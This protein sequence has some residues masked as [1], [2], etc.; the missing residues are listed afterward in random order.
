VRKAGRWELRDQGPPGDKIRAKI[1]MGS[2]LE[3]GLSNPPI[4][5]SRIHQTRSGQLP[6]FND[7]IDHPKT[8]HEQQQSACCSSAAMTS[9]KS[10]IVKLWDRIV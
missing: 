1:A 10:R 4:K 9:S 7:E 3:H 5:T 8:N 6:D 2:W